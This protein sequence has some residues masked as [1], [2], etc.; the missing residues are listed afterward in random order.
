MTNLGSANITM[1]VTVTKNVI[2]IL[3]QKG[4]LNKAI[5]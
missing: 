4:V 5:E 3:L 2:S 1:V